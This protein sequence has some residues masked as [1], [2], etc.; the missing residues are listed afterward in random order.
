[1]VNIFFSLFAFISLDFESPNK[2]I[3]FG[4]YVWRAQ[5]QTL[6]YWHSSI[7]LSTLHALTQTKHRNFCYML[8]YNP[9]HIISYKVAWLTMTPDW[10]ILVAWTAWARYNA[11][12]NANTTTSTSSLSLPSANVEYACALCLACS[13]L[14]SLSLSHSWCLFLVVLLTLTLP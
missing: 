8:M 14:F 3:P 13:S 9:A 11:Q 5:T 6:S 1:M 10:I 4:A 7:S 12:A 2:C